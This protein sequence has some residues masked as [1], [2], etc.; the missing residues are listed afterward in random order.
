MLPE[1]VSS[2]VYQN[3]IK[4][5]ILLLSNDPETFLKSC[6]GCEDP[7]YS[8]NNNAKLI[9][10]LRQHDEQ[11]QKIRF[12]LVQRDAKVDVLHSRCVLA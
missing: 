6:E 7:K 12:Q 4:C 2:P 9:V 8:P 11:L 10:L 5:D 3:M 1:F